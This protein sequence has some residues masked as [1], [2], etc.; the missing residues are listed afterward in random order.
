MGAPVSYQSDQISA[1]YD[2]E[3]NLV[4][5]DERRTITIPYDEV[6]AFLE[7]AQKPAEG[8]DEIIDAPQD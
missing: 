4:I 5:G 2:E 7:W 6:D 1:R 8:D 3:R